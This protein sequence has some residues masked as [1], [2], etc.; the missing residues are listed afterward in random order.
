M[1]KKVEAPTKEAF[2]E[3]RENPVAE[4]FFSLLPDAAESCRAKYAEGFNT[5]GPDNPYFK[6]HLQ[7]K[8]A[9]FIEIEQADYY[10]LTGKERPEDSDE[11]QDNGEN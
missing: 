10:D 1:S 6:S 9:A 3:W 2:D 4:W 11:G 8:A 5:D 7:G